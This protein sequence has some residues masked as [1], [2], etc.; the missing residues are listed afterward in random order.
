MIPYQTKSNKLTGT[1]LK[2]VKKGAM[3][4]YKEIVSFTKRRPYLRSA[5]FRK[6]RKKQKI[7]L[8]YFWTHL[9]QKSPK[10]RFKRL[11]Y[12]KASIDLIKNSRNKPV[13]KQNPNDKNEILHRFAG[14]T[15]SKELFYVQIKE[16]AKLDKIYF[17]SCFPPE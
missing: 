12:F 10:E 16:D 9:Y 5:Y 1:S 11:K 15:R 17:M 13:S 14:L 6:R 8:D 7:F 2:E 4:L 3:V